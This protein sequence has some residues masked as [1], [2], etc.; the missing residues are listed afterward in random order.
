MWN[1]IE[2]GAAKAK[3]SKKKHHVKKDKNVQVE[4]AAP[5]EEAK[6]IIEKADS[7]L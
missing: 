3:K 6:K 5:S 2:S 1:Q 4:N 7:G